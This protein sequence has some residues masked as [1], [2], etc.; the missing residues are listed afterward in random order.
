MTAHPQV[1][2]KLRVRRDFRRQALS[3]IWLHSTRDDASAVSDD[4]CAGAVRIHAAQGG[5]Y[6]HPIQD[7]PQHL[8]LVVDRPPVISLL[9]NLR[10]FQCFLTETFDQLRSSFLVVF[11]IYFRPP[12]F[13]EQLDN[14]DGDESENSPYLLTWSPLLSKY[15][16]RLSN[17]DC[18]P[19]NVRCSSNCRLTRLF[20]DIPALE[21]VFAFYTSIK[22]IK[23]ATIPVTDTRRL[24]ADGIV[25]I[26]RKMNYAWFQQE[27]HPSIATIMCRQTSKL[28][29]R[30]QNHPRRAISHG[31]S[32]L[33]S[34]EF[35]ASFR[36]RVIRNPMGPI[37]K[38]LDE[39]YISER[40]DAVSPSPPAGLQCRQWIVKP[41]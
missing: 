19:A 16:C 18:R 1:I 35:T 39:M 17:S 2:L 40:E 11:Q 33:M 37:A 9:P 28:G 3:Q 34:A 23:A 38:T 36:D 26:M 12:N 6:L 13:L 5:T 21:G 7:P 25:N 8:H 31:N 41:V 10:L 27:A 32:Q 20:R 4:L 29:S 30:D 15:L 14:D 22:N 24:D